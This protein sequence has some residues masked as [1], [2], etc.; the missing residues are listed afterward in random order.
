M[1]DCATYVVVMSSVHDVAPEMAAWRAYL[2]TGS[3]RE[4]A[5]R[6]AVHEVT[7]RKRIAALRETYDVRTNAQLADVL[8]RSAA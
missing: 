1:T 3:M 6:L 4:A 8:A 2:E 5:L 7:I